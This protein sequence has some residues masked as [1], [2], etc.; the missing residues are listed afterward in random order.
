MAYSVNQ[1]PSPSFYNHQ[2]SAMKKTIIYCLLAMLC[3]WVKGD[4]QRALWPGDRMPATRLAA[5]NAGGGIRLGGDQDTI[6]LVDFFATWCGPCVAGLPKL[7]ALQDSLQ[8]RLQVLLVTNQA[9]AL[10]KPFFEKRPAIAAKL[11]I[12]VAD[13]VLHQY[14]PHRLLPHQVLLGKNGMVAAVTNHDLIHTASINKLWHDMPVQFPVK[15]DFNGYAPD[16][17]LSVHLQGRPNHWQYQSALTGEMEGAGTMQGRKTMASLQRNFYYNHPPGML[18]RSLIRFQ[19]GLPMVFDAGVCSVLP[20]RGALKDQLYCYEGITPAGISDTARYRW[21]WEDLAAKLGIQY[22]D[23][24]MAWPVCYFSVP[25]TIKKPLPAFAGKAATRLSALVED[26]NLQNDC[27]EALYRAGHTLAKELMI[28]LADGF[29]KWSR[30]QQLLW[31]QEQ[32]ISLQTRTELIRVR[33]IETVASHF[34]TI[35]KLLC[36]KKSIAG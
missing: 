1:Q 35:N 4:A 3:I 7:L 22:R 28:T 30:Q 25:G 27:G 36:T 32:G 5:W 12:I 13:T 33:L 10:L 8:G 29:W 6:Q 26:L 15:K 16:M 11:K 34:S 23:S 14:F 19:P 21:M 24:L 17:P 31:L 9:E 18:I 2:I 20:Q